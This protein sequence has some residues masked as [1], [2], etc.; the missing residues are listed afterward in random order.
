MKV[1]PFALGPFAAN[2][3]VVEAEGCQ[4][5]FL[6]DPGFDVEQVLLWLQ[7]RNKKPRAVLLTHAHLDHA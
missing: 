4:E 1:T 6:V 5:V 3:L 2:C 7:K